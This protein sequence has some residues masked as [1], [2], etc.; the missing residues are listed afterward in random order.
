MMGFK[1]SRCARILLG[2]IELMQL[3]FKAGEVGRPQ[4]EVAAILSEGFVQSS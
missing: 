1:T 4:T 2:G 3:H